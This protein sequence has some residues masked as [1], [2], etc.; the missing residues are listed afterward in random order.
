MLTCTVF[1]SHAYGKDIYPMNS[2]KIAFKHV[3]VTPDTLILRKQLKN[4]QGKNRTSFCGSY[5]RGLTLHED[6][7]V[8]SF[9]VANQIMGGIT[10]YPIMKK[11]LLDNLTSKP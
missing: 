10:E 9:K 7:L 2:K 6:A 3:K 4:I 1:V 5:C 8:S 11:K